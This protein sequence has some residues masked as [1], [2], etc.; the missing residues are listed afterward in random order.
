MTRALIHTYNIANDH[1][2]NITYGL[3]AG[4]CLL[5]AIYVFNVYSIIATT[6]SIQKIQSQTVSLESNVENLDSKYLALSSEIS[7]DTLSAHGFTAG[8][9][10]AYIS[11]NASL[12]RVSLGGNEL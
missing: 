6:V 8:K 9:V 5:A 4:C 10:S 3:L 12:G 1:R 11:R 2:L 7:P